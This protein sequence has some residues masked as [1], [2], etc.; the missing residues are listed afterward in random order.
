LTDEWSAAKYLPEMPQNK[1]QHFVP[2]AHMKPFSRDAEGKAINV[3]NITSDNL[4]RDAPTRGQ[5][6]RNYFYSDASDLRLEK[7]L[8]DIEGRYAETVRGLDGGK[9]KPTSADLEILRFFAH[10][11]MNR[12]EMAIDRRRQAFALMHGASAEGE[13]GARMPPPPEL[14]DKEFMMMSMRD[15]MLTRTYIDDLKACVVVNNTSTD[16][17]TSD[18][19]TV[20]TNRYSF[21][22]LRHGNFGLASTGA[23][24]LLPLGPRMLF[25]CYDGG[26]YT[27]PNKR[28]GLLT[29]SKASDVGAINELQF[30]KAGRNI[31]FSDWSQHEQV[32]AAFAAASSRR[33]DLWSRVN[34][35]VPSETDAQGKHYKAATAEERITA[36]EKLV[37]L[38][39]I[40]PEPARWMS[41]LKFR[42][43]AKYVETGTAAGIIRPGQVQNLLRKKAESDERKR[44]I[45]PRNVSR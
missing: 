31:Y 13:M 16:F 17:V 24:L 45:I 22:K 7:I 19:P 10:V 21:Q 35:L 37:N 41:E 14:S 3:F 15:A 38:Q 39:A 30:I 33:R 12:T 2:K 42:S 36:R 29:I 27:I 23:M 34:V 32:R 20:F 9:K 6:A 18:D 26:A 5:C 4:V 44:L 11:Q 25:L 28:G 8:Q 43:P 1:S 40:Y